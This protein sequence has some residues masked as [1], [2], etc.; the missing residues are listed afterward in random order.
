[1]R[2][3][4]VD[5]PIAKNFRN[6]PPPVQS[7]NFSKVVSHRRPPVVPNT[8]SSLVRWFLIALFTFCA[9]QAASQ[10]CPTTLCTT[11]ASGGNFNS[12]N[13][14]AVENVGST[15]INIT[16]FYQSF[17]SFGTINYSVYYLIGNYTTVSGNP[18]T[19]S[20]PWTLLG[21]ATLSGVTGGQYT[22]VFTSPVSLSLTP[23]QKLSFWVTATSGNVAY[24]TTPSGSPVGSVYVTNGTLSIYNGYGASFDGVN[25]CGCFSPRTWNGGITYNILASDSGSINPADTSITTTTPVA[26]SIGAGSSISLSNVG[27]TVNPVLAGGTLVLNKG[28]RSSLAI[29]IS[30]AGGTINSPSS[31]LAILSGLISG[32]GGLTFTGTGTTVL[33]GANIYT[34]GTTVSS[35]TLTVAGTA[36]TGTGDVVVSTLGK[37]MGTGTITGN[38]IVGGTLKP[39]NSPGY[40]STT[41]NVTLNSGAIYQQDIAGTTQAN[42]L[43]PVGA[44][45][46]YSSMSVGGQFTINSGSTLTPALSNLFNVL[47]SGYG[48]TPYT[49]VLG[50]RFR[51]VT[52]DGGISGKFSTLT[53]PAELTAGTQFLPF[54]NM[55]G[56]NS[57]DLA[58]IPTSYAMTLSSSSSNTRSVS[59]ALDKMVV[60]SQA[61]VS[62][63]T[64]DQLLYAI[65][66][67]SASSLPSYTQGLAGEIYPTTVAVVSQATLRAQQAVMTHLGDTTSG[68]IMAAGINPVPNGF[69]NIAIPGQAPLANVSSNPSVNPNA[70]VTNATLNSGS[71][72]GEIAYQRGNRS[73]DDNASGY[74]SNLY[75]LVFG[76][77]AYSQ[78][79]IKIGGGLALSNT[80]V[81]A[82]QGTGTVQQGALFIYAKMP[83]QEFVL[84]AMASY[85]MNSTDTSRSDVTGLSNGFSTKGVKG[86]DAL[87]SIGLSRSIELDNLRITPYIRA[88]GQI[89]NQSSFTEGSSPAA[90]SVDSF[91]GNGVRGV[92]GVALGSK[93][94]NP[95]NENYTYRVNVGVGADS[96]NLI[97]P[98][99]NASLAGMPTTIT[100]P[101]AGST[102]AQAGLYGTV[103]FADNAYAYAG[104]AGEFRS[105]STLGNVSVG[106]RIQ[107]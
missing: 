53:Q 82:N 57:I 13:I 73:G 56:S 38:V 9:S 85:G 11:L 94:T 12:G 34:G 22:K 6:A 19:S 98:T 33:S 91:N 37:M 86:S 81:T 4:I 97:N 29:S 70:T 10:T 66:A 64:Q 2:V 76:I 104:V 78:D 3:L 63:S 35:G 8:S 48:S 87:L 61:G 80:N 58:V 46:Y 20:T 50:D 99:L 95:M 93:V 106:L 31:G 7:I 60:A 79:G 21:S 27:V 51:I 103:K 96:A 55:A 5:S 1:M 88:T 25:P 30:S 14:F 75:Q 74:S 26:P 36:P 32:S 101:K 24:S 42:R 16:N 59:S 102:F 44:T 69:N 17:Y 71:A 107:F 67:Q 68:S 62:T 90:L 92:I 18:L 15:S 72:W 89:V 39:G 40:L 84:D 52:A 41:G 49:P 47:E 105:G 23:S 54:Y 43:S 83:I 77:D 45:G 65:S 28:D 100:T